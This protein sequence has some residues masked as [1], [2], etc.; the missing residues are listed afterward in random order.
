METEKIAE[1]IIGEA[2]NNEKKP[3]RKIKSAN[4]YKNLF[5]FVMLAYPV[6]QFLVFWLYVNI[7]SFAMSFQRFDISKGDY[8]FFGL[9]NFKTI[10]NSIFGPSPS[11]KYIYALKN[12]LYVFLFNNFIIVPISVIC[13][14]LLSKKVLGEKFFRVVF[15]LPSIISIVAMTMMYSFMFSM[16]YGPINKILEFLHMEG[17]IPANGWFGD[18]KT[19][20]PLIL[21]YCLWTGIGY[22]VLLLAGTIARV[23]QEIIEAGQLDGVGILRE[24][25]NIVLPLIM[26]TVA[27]LFIMGTTS[28]FT[29]FLPSMLLAKGGP[30]GEAYTIAYLV[31][32]LTERG[33]YN[34]AAAIG[35]LFTVIGVPI[36]MI[37]KHF[38]DKLVAKVEF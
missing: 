30:A 25:F 11:P 5:L 9:N 16:N 19:L 2:E 10:F 13:A 17:L 36:I 28:M 32:E 7:D 8:V 20:F 14:Y 6:V 34:D 37:V 27:T 24:F 21:L 26:P 29:F 4:V 15:F 1:Q 31:V 38:M 23:P 33:T 22:N 35:M 18:E 3:K 12:S